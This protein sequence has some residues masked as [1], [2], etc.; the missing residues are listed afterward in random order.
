MSNKFNNVFNN[1]MWHNCEIK[2]T[3]IHYCHCC[4]WE[5]L[6]QAYYHHM[7]PVPV[8]GAIHHTEAAAG[9][10]TGWL[11]CSC[12]NSWR[13]SQTCD[14]YFYLFIWIIVSPSSGCSS[15]GF[16]FSACLT[17]LFCLL[18]LDCFFAFATILH[19]EFCCHCSAT[20]LSL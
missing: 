1:K 19:P 15:W 17:S 3:I 4:T 8:G 13:A 2:L 9:L 5:I 7:V 11:Y 12:A 16:N 10:Y 20:A 6:R 18:S 14:F